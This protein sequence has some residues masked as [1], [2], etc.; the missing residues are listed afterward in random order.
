METSILRPILFPPLKMHLTYRDP[1]ETEL[2]PPI[3]RHS[4][5]KLFSRFHMMFILSLRA[6][7][8]HAIILKRLYITIDALY[9]SYSLSQLTLSYSLSRASSIS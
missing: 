4:Q 2:V 9:I 7:E 1:N 5:Y 6:F 3:W 8:K